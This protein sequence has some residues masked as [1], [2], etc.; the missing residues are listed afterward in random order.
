MRL[1]VNQVA[2]LAV[3]TA[4]KKVIEADF[5]NLGRR[6]ITS[7][8]PAEFTMRFIGAHHHHQG[9]PTHDGGEPFFNAQV[10]RVSALAL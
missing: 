2:V 8:V 7:N 4:T 3:R 6:G 10:T 5:K 1:K 9:V